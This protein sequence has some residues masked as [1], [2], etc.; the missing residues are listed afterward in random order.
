MNSKLILK[1]YALL[2]VAL[3][4]NQYVI[5]II[6]PIAE[7]QLRLTK[8]EVIRKNWQKVQLEQQL[9]NLKEQ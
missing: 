9:S 6:Q 5:D 4:R 2:P 1:I 8:Q 3:K 7:E